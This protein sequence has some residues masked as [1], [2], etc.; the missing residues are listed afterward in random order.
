M[1]NREDY[2][3]MLQ[4]ILDNQEAQKEAFEEFREEVLEK[5]NNLSMPGRDFGVEQ[6]LAEIDDEDANLG[7]E[8]YLKRNT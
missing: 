2:M 6:E 7:L 4:E 8:E 5:L 1:A 3:E